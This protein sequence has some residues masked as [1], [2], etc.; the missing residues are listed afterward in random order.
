MITPRDAL[1]GKLWSAAET[2]RSIYA[3]V[4]VG[5]EDPMTVEALRVLAKGLE[6]AAGQLAD[7]MAD[8]CG[9]CNGSRW[10]DDEN[11]QP[12]DYERAVGRVIGSGRIPCGI[13]NH[14]GW[15]V[16]DGA[17]EGSAP[18]VVVDPAGQT[19]GTA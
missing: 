6:T 17:T 12:E 4:R 10:V 13:C 1:T 15:S 7:L 19:G 8:P 5:N 11:W 16:P 9:S 14:G 2:A 3:I 18:A